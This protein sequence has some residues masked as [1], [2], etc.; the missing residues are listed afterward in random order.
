[1]DF[2]HRNYLAEDNFRLESQFLQQNKSKTYQLFDAAHQ[3]LLK[4]VSMFDE[5]CDTNK[6]TEIN[7][8]QLKKKINSYLKNFEREIGN[9]RHFPTST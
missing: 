9:V 7:V 4:I 2:G 1:M 6:E 3:N 8:Y 5:F